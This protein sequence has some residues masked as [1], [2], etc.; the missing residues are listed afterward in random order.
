MIAKVPTIMIG[1]G[2][3]GSEIVEK[4]EIKTQNKD[5][6]YKKYVRDN[7]QFVLMD[8]DENSMRERRRNGYQGYMVSLAGDVS[9]GKCLEW[10]EDARKDW[11]PGDNIFKLK[12]IAE[13]AGQVRSISRLAFHRAIRVGALKPLFEAIEMLFRQSENNTGQELKIVLVST[14]AGGTGSGVVLPLAM[15]L[16]EYMKKTYSGSGVKI[17]A[18]LILPDVLESLKSTNNERDNLFSNGYAALKEISYFMYKTDNQIKNDMVYIN[19]PDDDGYGLVRHND[20]PFDFCFLFGRLTMKKKVL[21]NLEAYKDAVFKCLYT[22]FIGSYSSKYFSIEDNMIIGNINKAEQSEEG[23]RVVLSRFASANCFRVFYPYKE[24]S[25][26]L[27]LNWALDVME[28]EWMKY[29]REVNNFYVEQQK[30]KERGLEVVEKN[31]N[32]SFIDAVER[33]AE[34]G[35][36]KALKLI[37]DKKAADTLV[38]KFTEYIY[39][40]VNDELLFWEK[41]RDE[42]RY[43]DKKSNPGFVTQFLVYYSQLEKEIMRIENKLSENITYEICQIHNKEEWKEYFIE[44]YFKDKN[45]IW[46]SPNEIRYFL[47]RI[48]MV[49]SKKYEETGKILEEKKNMFKKCEEEMSDLENS[50]EM[51][52]I[53]NGGKNKRI[54]EKMSSGYDAILNCSEELLRVIVVV[55]CYKEL[56]NYIK[57]ILAE[58]QFFFREYE[59]VIEYFKKR[60]QELKKWFN[61]SVQGVDRLVCTKEECINE[62]IRTMK[63]QKIYSQVGGEVSEWIYKFCNRKNDDLYKKREFAMQGEKIK[64]MWYGMF[65]QYYGKDFNIN[66]FEAFSREASYEGKKDDVENYIISQLERA[67]KEYSVPLLTLCRKDSEERLSNCIYPKSLASGM[68]YSVVKDRYFFNAKA[69][70]DEDG[71]DTDEKSIIFYQNRYGLE[72]FYVDFFAY[73]TGKGNVFPIGAGYRAYKSVLERITGSEKSAT[74]TPHIDRHWHRNEVMPEMDHKMVREHAKWAFKAIFIQC[75]T[76]KIKINSENQMVFEDGQRMSVDNAVNY[77]IFNIFE[78]QKKYNDGVWD[79]K[80]EHPANCDGKQEM[81]K[82]KNIYLQLL[83]NPDY[84]KFMDNRIND[85]LREMEQDISS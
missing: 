25:E 50:E 9:I 36:E 44:F 78:A 3:I 82:I 31:E 37:E 59:D 13:G 72:S 8:T 14:L 58:Y 57:R 54:I 16:K 81:S 73:D 19:L 21:G 45:E 77:Y 22:Q 26:Y 80:R 1:L 61:E 28:K 70:C 60:M 7:I 10:D 55:K 6:S 66:L 68:S 84:M 83:I 42:Q 71:L 48:L 62:M 52:K 43:L 34:K 41:I 65:K 18:C 4:V 32:E 64:N 20:S 75:M 27:S 12:S 33:L 40:N 17:N 76:Q 47:C 74:L 30:R 2:G 5:C 35:D 38:D 67:E 11:Y 24:I 53:L 23:R 69:V 29:D 49:L 79:F 56:E 63:N 51:G 39:S 46:K 15:H 85:A